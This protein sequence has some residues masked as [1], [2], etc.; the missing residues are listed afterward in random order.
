MPCEGKKGNEGKE[1]PQ[2]DRSTEDKTSVT[3]DWKPEVTFGGG[4]GGFGLNLRLAITDPPEKLDFRQTTAITAKD[5]Y[6][7][8]LLFAD[9]AAWRSLLAKLCNASAIKPVGACLLCPFSRARRY[10]T[11]FDMHM[12]LWSGIWLSLR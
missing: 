8:R 4:F 7:C 2:R 3:E 5:G 12:V 10:S 6:I 11:L 1:K 9:S